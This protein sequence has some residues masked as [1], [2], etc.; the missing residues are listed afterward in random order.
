MSSGSIFDI[1]EMDNDSICEVIPQVDGGIDT[2]VSNAVSTASEKFPSFRYRQSLFETASE[3]FSGVSHVRSAPYSL[4]IYKQVNGIMNDSNKVPFEIDVND[5]TN[6]NI[7]C[8][9]GFTKKPH[10]GK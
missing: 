1:T 6:V 4:N 5:D 8:S 2:P 3:T 7:S 9:S 10:P